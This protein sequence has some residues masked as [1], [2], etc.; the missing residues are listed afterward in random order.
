MACRICRVERSW[1]DNEGTEGQDIDAEGAGEEEGD[2]EVDD[3]VETMLQ[4]TTGG[5]RA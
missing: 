4:I 5:V 2:S 1:R 3:L